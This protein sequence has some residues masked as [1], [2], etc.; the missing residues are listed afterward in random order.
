M[1]NQR[2]REDRERV[3]AL[4]AEAQRKI[5]EAQR[6]LA[7][8]RKLMEQAAEMDTKANEQQKTG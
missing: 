3:K 4:Q 8:S 7:E 6:L 2:S 5:E 1:P